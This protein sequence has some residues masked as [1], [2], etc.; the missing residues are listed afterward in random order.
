MVYCHAYDYPYLEDYIRSLDLVPILYDDSTLF[1]QESSINQTFIRRV[2]RR[3]KVCKFINT[4]QL[5][6]KLKLDEYTSFIKKDFQIYDYS[7]HNIRI[8][9]TGTYLPYREKTEETVALREFLKQPKDF[10]FAVI[11]SDSEH[12]TKIMQVLKKRGY[13]I[14]HVKGWNA[15]RDIQVGRCKALLNIHY[16][17]D[18]Q[19]YESIRC[20][21]WQ[22]AGMQIYSEPC[23]DASDVDGSVIFVHNFST[24]QFDGINS[25]QNASK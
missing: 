17:G 1:H 20:N 9:G 13:T 19:I 4:E 10:D 14:H 2:P 23:I 22:F 24:F 11:G 21:R 7:L 6:V 15:E 16:D 3:I 12:R 25:K 18:Y 5:S 8:T